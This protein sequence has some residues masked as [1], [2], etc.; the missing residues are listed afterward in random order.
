MSSRNSLRNRALYTREADILANA[1]VNDSPAVMGIDQLS[2]AIQAHIA[3]GRLMGYHLV[4]VRWSTGEFALMF[5]E[6]GTDMPDPKR[7]IEAYYECRRAARTFPE[8][9]QS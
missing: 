6:P 9:S 8:G 5:C 3:T 4:S 7:V 2:P 1:M